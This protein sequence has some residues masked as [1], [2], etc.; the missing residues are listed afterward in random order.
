MG[1][2]KKREA[3]G[4]AMDMTPVIDMSFL[5]IV[6]FLCLPFKSLDAK[7]A[8]HLPPQGFDAT[9]IEHFEEVR[10]QVRVVTEGSGQPAVCS[11]RCGDMRTAS[12]DEVGAWIARRRAGAAATGIKRIIGEVDADHRAPHKYVIAVANEFVEHGVTDL[13]FEGT[14]LPTPATRK[15]RILP[16]PR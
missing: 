4:F 2:K 5:L 15:M 14:A 6:F 3:Q 11:F 9:L 13:A 12:I 10:I 16:T 8:A 1:V 7:L